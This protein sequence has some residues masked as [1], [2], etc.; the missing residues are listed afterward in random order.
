MRHSLGRFFFS[1]YK[2]LNEIVKKNT[3]ATP[4][5]LKK[6]PLVKFS[7]RIQSVYDHTKIEPVEKMQFN[8][9]PEGDFPKCVLQNQYEEKTPFI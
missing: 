4:N 8:I 3:D 7:P 5:I 1:K 2:R 9:T 6:E